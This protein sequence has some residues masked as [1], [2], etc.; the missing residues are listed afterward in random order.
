MIIIWL[1]LKLSNASVVVKGFHIRPVAN[2]HRRVV[3]VVAANAL[4]HNIQDILVLS[5]KFM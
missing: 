5:K 2:M 1:V 3:V 4:L